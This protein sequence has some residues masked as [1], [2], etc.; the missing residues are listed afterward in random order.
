MQF[1]VVRLNRGAV[2]RA[3][4]VVKVEVSE[5]YIGDVL[6]GKSR[7]FHG[8]HQIVVSKKTV[9]LPK[10]FRLFVAHPCIDQC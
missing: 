7:F 9:V 5:Q 10:T 4:T 6:R 2:Y 8:A 1:Q 3:P